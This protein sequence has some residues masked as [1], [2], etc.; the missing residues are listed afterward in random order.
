[1]TPRVTAR[2]QLASGA[3]KEGSGAGRIRGRRGKRTRLLASGKLSDG[4][5]PPCDPAGKLLP[6]AALLLAG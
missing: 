6:P 4:R 5:S 1:L 3:G 2:T